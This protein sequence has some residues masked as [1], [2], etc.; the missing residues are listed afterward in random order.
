VSD[1]VAEASGPAGPRA[2][3]A[4]TGLDVWEVVD[5]VRAVGNHVGRAARYLSLDEQQVRAA[6]RHDAEAGGPGAD[7]IA[8][9]R[10]LAE[11]AGRRLRR[12]RPPA[13]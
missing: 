6:L 7:R 5:A 9:E 3:L 4:G 11:E 2:T 12:P 8:R 1:R 10:A 13:S